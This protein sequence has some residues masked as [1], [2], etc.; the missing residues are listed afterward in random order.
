MRYIFLYI[1]I[2]HTQIKCV[3]FLIKIFIMQRIF[4]STLKTCSHLHLHS[5]LLSFI[6][7]FLWNNIK[8]YYAVVNTLIFTLKANRTCV[9]YW[10]LFLPKLFIF[11]LFF[12]SFFF[13]RIIGKFYSY[14]SC[15][16]YIKSDKWF[17]IVR[18]I[19]LKLKKSNIVNLCSLIF[20]AILY[21]KRQF[22]LFNY[23]L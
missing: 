20:F 2:R 11:I 18:K 17:K 19:I 14:A 7:L 6:R 3:I 10:L 13:F 15:L 4:I 5:P 1:Y 12:Y 23:S 9:S 21:T 8:K 22:M 16:M